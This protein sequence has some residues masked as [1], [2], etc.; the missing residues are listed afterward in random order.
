MGVRVPEVCFGSAT[1]P[2]L[3]TVMRHEK[4]IGQWTMRERVFC[5]HCGYVAYDGAPI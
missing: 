5:P 2:H 4:Y 3:N 1:N